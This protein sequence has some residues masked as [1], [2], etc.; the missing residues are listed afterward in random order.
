MKNFYLL[1]FIFYLLSFTGVAADAQVRSFD[2]LFP[3]LPPHIKTQAFTA[4]GYTNCV[5]DP[6]DLAIAPNID[7]DMFTGRFAVGI[8][9]GHFSYISENLLLIPHPAERD[10]TL[11]NIYDSLQQVRAMTAVKY[12]SY[13][14]NKWVPLFE[15]ASRIASPR[16]QTPLPDPG[17]RPDVPDTETLYIK[18]KDINLGNTVY[19]SELARTGNALVYT[20]TNHKASSLFLVTVIKPEDF[21]SRIYLEPV[22][23]GVLVYCV[24]C[25]RVSG[26]VDR[27]IDMPSALKKR[28]DVLVEWALTGLQTEL[29]GFTF[30]TAQDRE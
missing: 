6:L 3:A 20:V 11:R 12:H 18:V 22:A 7:G 19:R 21:V 25:I 8:A 27:M 4:D 5:T 24:A 9:A 13:T 14:R 29:P 23:E 1:S 28:L 30:T 16:K 10:V 17:P 2:S 26:F 15:E